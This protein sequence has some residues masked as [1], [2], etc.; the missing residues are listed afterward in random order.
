MKF[1]ELKNVINRCTG[2]HDQIL[3]EPVVVLD[4]E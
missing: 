1:C 4:G 2:R 3:R